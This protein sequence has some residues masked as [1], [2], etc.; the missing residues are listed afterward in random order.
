MLGVRLDDETERMLGSVA[1]AQGRTK[2]DVAR[3]AIRRYVELNDEA[4]RAE[5]KRQSR[6]AAGSGAPS[7]DAAW[8]AL[9]DHSGWTS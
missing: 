8:E 7:E 2:S 3:G 9:A 5:A 1:R 4:Y 6:V